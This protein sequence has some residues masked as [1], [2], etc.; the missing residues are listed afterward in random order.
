MANT[1][2]VRILNSHQVQADLQGLS[3]KLKDQINR[4]A[5]RK[6]LAPISRQAKKNMTPHKRSGLLRKAISSV[7]KLYPSGVAFG[8]VG[9]D[10]SLT[11]MYEGRKAWPQK[12]VHLLE[13]GTRPHRIGKGSTLSR[14]DKPN[15]KEVQQGYKHPGA[16]AFKPLARAAASSQ[17]QAALAYAQAVRTELAKLNSKQ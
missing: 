3:D 1:S 9:P 13:Y 15:R 8:L 12:Y 6:A 16:K 17:S 4:K 7:V 2:S 10:R 5:M 11:G 14:A